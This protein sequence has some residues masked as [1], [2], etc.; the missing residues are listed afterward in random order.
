MV[1]LKIRR[2]QQILNGF[3]RYLYYVNR[4]SS[5]YESK[6]FVNINSAHY[7]ISS[8]EW[9]ALADE[10]MVAVRQ[11]NDN[12]MTVGPDKVPPFFVRDCGFVLVQPPAAI[13][14]CS[15]CVSWPME[16]RYKTVQCIKRG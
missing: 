10:V 3:D 4:F 16:K 11:S 2:P 14:N 15:L 9:S 12:I 7:L 5:T 1:Y 6:K 13:F 8:K